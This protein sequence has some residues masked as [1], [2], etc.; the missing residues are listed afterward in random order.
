MSKI[1]FIHGFASS[2]SSPKVADLS[3]MLQQQV[4]APDL[5]HQP[6][7]DIATLE[8]IITDNSIQLVVGSS[9]GGFYA[10]YL[11][12]KYHKNTVLIN[13]SLTPQITL[14][15]QLGQVQ[16]FKRDA[17]FDWTPQHIE[18]LQQL[19]D[20]IAVHMQ[21][22]N[23]DLSQLLVLLAKHD[24]RLNY[25]DALAMFQGAKMIIDEEQDHRFSD[26]QRYQLAIQA[27]YLKQ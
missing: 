12:L 8:K 14:M 15:D 7:A 13:P 11:M 18:Q 22:D 17:D 4:I 20:E 2:G 6:L 5:T 27:L 24:E 16:S 10:L 3:T 9:L 26:I 21:Q 25:Q 19:A 1:L 23:L